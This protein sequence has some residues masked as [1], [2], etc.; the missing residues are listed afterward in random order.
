M[1]EVEAAVDYVTLTARPGVGAELL[2]RIYNSHRQMLV[3]DGFHVKPLR[4]MGYEAEKCGPL[5]YGWRHDGFILRVS[6]PRANDIVGAIDTKIVNCTRIDV[7][8]TFK[9]YTNKD[10]HIK[11]VFEATKQLNSTRT[12]GRPAKIKLIDGNGDGDTMMIGSRQSARYGRIYD[13]AAES[14]DPNYSNCIRYEVEYKDE[15]A[16]ACLLR[17][18]TASNGA[19]ALR[20][21]V[22]SQFAAWG[23]PVPIEATSSDALAWVPREESDAERSERWLFA[24]VLPTLVRLIDSGNQHIVDRL[25]KHVYASRDG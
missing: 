11:A 7:Q 16:N 14:L 10:A 24:Q 8:L 2:G 1:L 3:P 6:G 4:L 5:T 23:V 18:Q 12:G 13:K 15:L 17:I 25:F 19:Q 9:V 21:V 20:E 22:S